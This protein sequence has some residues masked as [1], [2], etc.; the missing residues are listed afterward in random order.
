MARAIVESI[1]FVAWAV[2]CFI[3][4]EAVV[5][6]ARAR[7]RWP[8]IA[9]ATAMLVVNSVVARGLGYLTPVTGA[10]STARILVAWFATELAAYWLHRAMHRVPLLW[11]VHRMHHTDVPLAWHQS[12]WIHPVDI[13]LFAI[14]AACVTWLVGA[15]MTAAPWFLLVRRAWG[16]LLHANVRWPATWLDHVIVTP[17]VHHRHHR[18]DLPPANFAGSF[19]FFDRAFGTWRR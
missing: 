2:P 1:A 18:E 16:I 3:L 11:R 4:V 12:W 14:T 17:A 6:R 7:I 19:A 10:A 13:A 8:A 15:P 5:P 9:L